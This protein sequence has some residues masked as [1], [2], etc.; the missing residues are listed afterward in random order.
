MTSEMEHFHKNWGVC[1]NILLQSLQIDAKSLNSR[2]R[3]KARFNKVISVQ[4]KKIRIKI[5]AWGSKSQTC[6]DEKYIL[7][8]LLI[9]LSDLNV[10]RKNRLRIR[11]CCLK[12]MVSRA[13]LA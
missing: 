6:L 10:F 8:K 12:V 4:R 9:R 2:T 1:S 5:E 11:D 7:S 3:M 13:I